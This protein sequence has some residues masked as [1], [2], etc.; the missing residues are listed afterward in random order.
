MI[1]GE[2]GFDSL[3]RAVAV[4]GIGFCNKNR[5]ILLITAQNKDG[6]IFMKEEEFALNLRGKKGF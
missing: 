3:F 1:S 2:L 5:F 4:L 6:L